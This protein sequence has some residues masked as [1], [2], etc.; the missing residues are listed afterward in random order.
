MQLVRNCA[1]AHK[2]QSVELYQLLLKST[3]AENTSTILE[4]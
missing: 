1:N 2:A 3:I 4:I